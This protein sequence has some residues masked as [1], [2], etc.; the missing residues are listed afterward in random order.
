M[1]SL[2]DTL[3]QSKGSEYGPHRGTTEKGRER[4]TKR[5]VD[6][7][8]YESSMTAVRTVEPSRTRRCEALG[9]RL[10]TAPLPQWEPQLDDSL[11]LA[12]HLASLM[13]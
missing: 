11:R 2:S 5:F 10:A 13:V 8:I 3:A 4:G 1:T 7:A 12:P 6:R 9:P